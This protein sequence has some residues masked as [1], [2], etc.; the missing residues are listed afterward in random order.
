[1]KLIGNILILNFML[2]CLEIDLLESLHFYIYL[3]VCV[4]NF[5]ITTM[6]EIVNQFEP[7]WDGVFIL[8]IFWM[9]SLIK[10]VDPIVFIRGFKSKTCK[11]LSLRFNPL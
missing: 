7:N 5:I 11:N 10:Y 6:A 9:S 8:Q 2:N 4:E 3:P 1:M